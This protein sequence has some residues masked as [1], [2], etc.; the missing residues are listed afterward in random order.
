MNDLKAAHN[1]DHAIAQPAVS[2][3]G[4]KAKAAGVVDMRNEVRPTCVEHPTPRTD[5]RTLNDHHHHPPHS[6]S[7]SNH[8]VAVSVQMSRVEWDNYERQ[9]IQPMMPNGDAKVMC[10]IREARWSLVLVRRDHNTHHASCKLA[11]SL[12]IPP[13]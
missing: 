7:A 1:L 11:G 12:A 8:R 3:K 5:N 4:H 2:A 13:T 6:H 10:Q 9:V